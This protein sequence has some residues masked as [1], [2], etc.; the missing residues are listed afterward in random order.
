MKR[1]LS[2]RESMV[3]IME[4]DRV[5]TIAGIRAK[6]RNIDGNFNVRVGVSIASPL[7]EFE[8]SVGFDKALGRAEGKQMK[9]KVSSLEIMQDALLNIGKRVVDR[10]CL[11]ERPYKVVPSY[12]I[13]ALYFKK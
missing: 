6:N 8:H 12:D 2:S 9:I 11:G 3:H 5:I 13:P 4:D 1:K 10:I 7:D